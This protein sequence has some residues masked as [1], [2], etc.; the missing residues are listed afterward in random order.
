LRRRG[1]GLGLALLAVVALGARSAAADCNTGAGYRVNLKGNT[2][3][4]LIDSSTRR[5]GGP[6]P[7]LRQDVATGDVVVLSSY[8]VSGTYVD[9]CVPPGTYRYGF[10]TPYD[11]SE[12]GCSSVYYWTSARVS[13]EVA[14]CQRSAGDQAPTEYPQG[15]PWPN[16][17]SPQ[18][19]CGGGCACSTERREVYGFDAAWIVG[20]LAIAWRRRWASRR[21]IP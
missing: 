6:V 2:V 7:L 8:C 19:S 16:N 3:T 5:C 21:P 20:A 14:G 12:Q 9:E 17:D 1:P 4:I 18:K 15:A 10:A 13:G 11:C